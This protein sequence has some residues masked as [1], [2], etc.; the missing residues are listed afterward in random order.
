MTEALNLPLE[1][2][3]EGRAGAMMELIQHETRQ[4]S[5]LPLSLHFQTHGPLSAL[6]RQFVE[7]PRIY[8]TIDAWADALGMSRRSFTRLFR[9]AFG[10]PPLAFRGR[11]GS[12]SWDS[13]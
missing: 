9:R 7:Q 4:S 1:Y 11:Y 10:S 13:A 6:C 3:L 8:Q 5:V 2:E 12:R